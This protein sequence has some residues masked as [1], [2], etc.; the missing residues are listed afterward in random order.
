MDEVFLFKEVV[1]V[2]AGL[3]LCLIVLVA[4]PAWGYEIRW[5]ED[6][7]PMDSCCR[8]VRWTSPAMGRMN[9]WSWDAT[10]SCGRF[11]AGPGWNG[12]EFITIG[13]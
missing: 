8:F 7:F 10:M 12:Q 6:K 5:Q 3:A 11:L 9:S 13:K 4:M 1:L 2:K